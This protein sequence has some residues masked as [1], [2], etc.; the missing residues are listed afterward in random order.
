MNSCSNTPA[1]KTF[2]LLPTLTGA[3]VVS[4]GIKLSPST[5][6][7]PP[8]SVGTPPFDVALYETTT[9]ALYEN[10]DDTEVRLTIEM[11]M[12]RLVPNPT[13]RALERH[14]ME[15]LDKKFTGAQEEDPIA[16]VHELADVPAEH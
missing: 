8:P 15:L 2:N 3:L 16:T 10:E 14:C 12:G 7:Q 6:I 9:G 13:E 4:I 11:C 5:R 1:T